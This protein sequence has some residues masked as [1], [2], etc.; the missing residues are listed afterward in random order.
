[1]AGKIDNELN[2]LIEMYKQLP[3]DARIIIFSNANALLA[4][5]E[6]RKQQQE[7]IA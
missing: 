6:M 5:E 3:E 2:E 7:S 4:S 1:M